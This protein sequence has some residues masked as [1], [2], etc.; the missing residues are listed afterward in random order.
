MG[1]LS[2]APTEPDL[3]LPGLRPLSTRGGKT[4]EFSIDSPEDKQV[5]ILAKEEQR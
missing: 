3:S 5:S 4:I 2:L 1:S